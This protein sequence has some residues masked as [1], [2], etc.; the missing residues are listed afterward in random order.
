MSSRLSILFLTLA[1]AIAVFPAASVGAADDPR[2]FPQTRYRIDDDRFWDFFQRRG[3]VKTFGYPVSNAFPLLGQQVQVY[4]REVMQIQ[5]NGSVATMNLLDDGLM[6]YTKIN[7]SVF[8]ASDKS[9]LQGAPGVGDRNYDARVQQFVRDSAPDAFDGQR[10]NFY[11][12]F[13]NTVSLQDAFPGGKGDPNLL[14]GLNLEIWG[15]PTSRP[16]Y[17]PTNGGFIYQRFQRG[18]MHFDAACGCTQGLLL[19]QY[20]KSM[21]TLRDLP[22]DLEEQARGSRFYGQLKPGVDAGVGRPRDLPNTDLSSAFRRDPTVVVDAGH[23]GK[24][25]GSS[26]TFPDGLVLAEKD[27]TLKVALRLVQLLSDNSFSALPTRTAD[28]GVNEPPRDLT[29]DDKITLADELQARVDLANNAQADLMLS[30]H[31]NGVANPGIRGTQIFYGDGRPTTERSKAFAELA[32]SSVVKALAEAGY[33]TNDR[34]ASS[35]SSVLG[36]TSH[37]YLLGPAS[38]II[39]RPTNMPAIIG[40]ALY[41]TNDDDANALRQDRVLEALARGYLEAIKSYFVK[42]PVA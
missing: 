24:E 26:H 3:G 32:D 10:V 13:V 27:L 39:K 18:I 25:I 23:G 30:V 12:T 22:S 38:E 28:R 11:S 7:G 41:L 17:D 2:Y 21:M 16:T 40:E 4:Q 36:A 6:P 19:G 34:K 5:P 35:D 29:G 37:F 20:L 42:F 33:A 9:L 15:L 8:P 14:F 1:F 31:F